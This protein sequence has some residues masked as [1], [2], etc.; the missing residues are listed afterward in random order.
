MNKLNVPGPK[1]LAMIEAAYAAAS[2]GQWQPVANSLDK[3]A[4][5]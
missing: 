1:S 2:T 5:S 3:K 4:E